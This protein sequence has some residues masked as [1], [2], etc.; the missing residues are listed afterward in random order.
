MFKQ[1]QLRL[2]QEEAWG[3][4]YMW[5]VLNRYPC[6][7]ENILLVNLCGLILDLIEAPLLTTLN[8]NFNKTQDIVEIAQ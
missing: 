2:W 4:R 3:G 8:T 5:L 6:S 7:V 1:M